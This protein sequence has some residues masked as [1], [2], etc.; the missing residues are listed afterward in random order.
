VFY[1]LKTETGV[2]S[3]SD[4]SCALRQAWG[5]SANRRGLRWSLADS[6]K[7]GIV[8]VMKMRWLLI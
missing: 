2:G 1:V 3:C 7:V 8:V 6:E 5:V 4:V